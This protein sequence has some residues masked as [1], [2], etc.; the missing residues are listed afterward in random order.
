MKKRN[1]IWA[2]SFTIIAL[3]ILLFLNL[4]YFIFPPTKADAA[5]KG[6]I[7]IGFLAPTTGNFAQ[8]GV[9]M[10]DGVKLFLESVNNSIAGR[11]IEVIY[12]D[13]GPGPDHAVG[14]ARKLIKHDRV[15]MVAGV[16]ITV[17]LTPL[18][19]FA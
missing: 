8:F 3:N 1:N 18:P 6:P 15:D 12:E 9:D 14:K 5:E 7:K 17:L 13:E 4:T 16:W 10:N 19:R 2:T 11:K